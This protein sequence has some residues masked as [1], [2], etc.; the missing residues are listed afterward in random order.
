MNGSPD[1]GLHAPGERIWV[2]STARQWSWLLLITVLGAAL[3][4]YHLGSWSIWVDEAHTWRDI[5]RP[6]SVFWK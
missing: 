4:M 5:T 3:R 1:P 2:Y 6:L